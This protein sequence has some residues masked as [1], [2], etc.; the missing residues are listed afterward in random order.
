LYLKSDTL[1]KCGFFFLKI[2]ILCLGPNLIVCGL[3][4]WIWGQGSTEY[5]MEWNNTNGVMRKEEEKEERQR[6]QM[7]RQLE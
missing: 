3:P 1:R 4:Y 5:G 6:K 7:T 2:V